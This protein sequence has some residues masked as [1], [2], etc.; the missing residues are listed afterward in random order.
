[1]PGRSDKSVD[2]AGCPF[3]VGWQSYP[4]L[5]RGKLLKLRLRDPRSPSC[6]RVR[7]RG[8]RLWGKAVSWCPPCLVGVAARSKV[9][10]CDLGCGVES[11]LLKSWWLC[12]R[13]LPC[14]TISRM[15]GQ[16][17]LLLLDHPNRQ[18]RY[19]VFDL[20]NEDKQVFAKHSQ[21]NESQTPHPKQN[22]VPL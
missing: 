2:F 13:Q 6:G 21:P 20:S 22:R 12:D 17:R 18:Q 7:G 11:V 5:V 16:K 3:V 4:P 9:Q 15:L 19:I 10:L 1:M 14:G 8:E